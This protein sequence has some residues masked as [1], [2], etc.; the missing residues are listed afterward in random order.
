MKNW[1]AYETEYIL[2][3]GG[4]FDE[5]EIAHFSKSNHVIMDRLTDSLRFPSIRSLMIPSVHGCCLIFEKTHFV[6]DD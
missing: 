5:K 2:N 3:H 1:D 6:I 4:H